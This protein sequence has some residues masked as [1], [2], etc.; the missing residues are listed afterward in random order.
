MDL[1]QVTKLTFINKFTQDNKN[2][3]G[4]LHMTTKKEGAVGLALGRNF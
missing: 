3:S 2:D 1:N 4:H